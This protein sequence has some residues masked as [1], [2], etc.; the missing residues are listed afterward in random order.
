MLVENTNLDES[1]Y[2]SDLSLYV[3]HKGFKNVD[4]ALTNLGMTG[5]KE[6][7]IQ[8]KKDRKD[9]IKN[10]GTAVRTESAIRKQQ[11]KETLEIVSKK[12]AGPNEKICRKCFEKKHLTD[13]YSDQR[14]VDKKSC[15]CISCVKEGVRLSKLK[16]NN[17]K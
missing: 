3:I 6:L 11:I 14:S 2:T 15:Y 12:T 1:E 7:K 4:H 10:R 16:K 13:F 17:G 9:Y 8:M 5:F